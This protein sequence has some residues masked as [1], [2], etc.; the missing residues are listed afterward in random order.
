MLADFLL[1]WVF[2][3]YSSLIYSLITNTLALI[4][5][6]HF[7]KTKLVSKDKVLVVI[8][9]LWFLNLVGLGLAIFTYRIET[10]LF[11]KFTGDYRMMSDITKTTFS[12][13]SGGT[14]S[15]I[16]FSAASSPGSILMGYV[17]CYAYQQPDK[18]K[19]I[20]Y[21]ILINFAVTF[22]V[23]SRSLCGYSPWKC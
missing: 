2:G 4:A 1:P 21:W 19:V 13:I 9:A 14:V 8:F 16:L 23:I 20:V 6:P 5:F 12:G 3:I 7:S 22:I 10:F 11:W 18:K 15:N 17:S